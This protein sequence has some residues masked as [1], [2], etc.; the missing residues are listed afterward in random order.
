PAATAVFNAVGTK[1]TKAGVEDRAPR[2][3]AE[4]EALGNSAAALA[5]SGNL[6]LLGGRRIDNHD[7]VQM[8]KALVDAANLA[9]RAIR[10]K[11]RDKVR[12]AGAVLNESCDR[13]HD[14]YQRG[15]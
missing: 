11:N 3:D 8:S 9:L 15:S 7:W 13:C 14:R 10:G 1:V 5:E 4:W 12:E 6:L 2:D